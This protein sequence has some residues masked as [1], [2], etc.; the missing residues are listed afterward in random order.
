MEWPRD[1][2]SRRQ[3]FADLVGSV[4]YLPNLLLAQ[5]NVETQLI[6]FSNSKLSVL[7]LQFVDTLLTSSTLPAPCLYSS[8]TAFNRDFFFL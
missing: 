7:H 2:S 8:L 5:K 4:P 1:S 6:F 3:S